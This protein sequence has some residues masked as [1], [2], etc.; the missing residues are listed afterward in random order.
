M[1]A[2]A[3]S[4]RRMLIGDVH[5]RGLSTL[6]IFTPNAN[7]PSAVPCSQ[8]IADVT[9]SHCPTPSIPGLQL[10]P[11]SR[12]PA[13][14]FLLGISLLFVYACTRSFP[15]MRLVRLF[16]L[17]DDPVAY[18]AQIPPLGLIG[19]RVFTLRSCVVVPFLG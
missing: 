9:S 19:R 12:R 6:P 2:S 16:C 11:G 10:C 1:S 14:M 3:H 7:S 8:W 5:A 4:R 15:G 18:R 17:Y 13:A